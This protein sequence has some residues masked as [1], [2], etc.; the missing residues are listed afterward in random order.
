M[1]AYK[2]KS[3]KKLLSVSAMFLASMG[4]SHLASAAYIYADD[5]AV[6]TVVEELTDNAA[7]HWRTDSSPS[8]PVVITDGATS[9]HPHQHFGTATYAGFPN[10]Y[11]EILGAPVTKSYA[12][13]EVDFAESTRYF[14]FK[15][16]NHSGDPFMLFL[17]D[18][19]GDFVDFLYEPPISSSITGESGGPLGRTFDY[20]ESYNFDF[21]VGKIILGSS[22]SSAYIYALDVASVPE[23][24]TFSLLMLGM[25]FFVARSCF[26]SLES[27]KGLTRRA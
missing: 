21:D 14:G 6:G 4:V 13:L 26:S 11:N 27:K 2:G 8:N 19:Q 16:E 3:M 20:S 1:N 5:F 15:A 22:D 24:Q 18:A 23:S 9:Q 12:A 10:L 25:F 17:F 7:L